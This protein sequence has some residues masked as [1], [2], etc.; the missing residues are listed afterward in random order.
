MDIPLIGRETLRASVYV[1][2]GKYEGLMSRESVK[3]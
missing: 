1:F 2:V 3:Q